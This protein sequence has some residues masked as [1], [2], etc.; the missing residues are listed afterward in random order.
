[1]TKRRMPKA[2][3]N[4]DNR[5]E[6]TLLGAVVA[7]LIIAACLTAASSLIKSTSKAQR[8]IQSRA[9]LTELGVTLGM[10]LNNPDLCRKALWS[11]G[12]T[13][14][15][16][17]IASFNPDAAS[18]V[19][20]GKR[21][22]TI[23]FGDTPLIS[24]GGKLN[25]ASTIRELSLS[26][27]D[28]TLRRSDASTIRYLANLRVSIDRDRKLAVGGGSSLSFPLHVVTNKS[29]HQITAC[30]RVAEA[31]GGLPG[32]ARGLVVRNLATTPDRAISIAYKDLVLTDEGLASITVR[33]GNLTAFINS[34]GAN[35]LDVGVKAIHSWYYL[36]VVSDGAN[37]V[38]LFSLSSTSPKLPSGYY[39]KA[40]VSAVS[41]DGAGNFRTFR[42]AGKAVQYAKAYGV[43][44]GTPW[45]YVGWN[46]PVTCMNPTTPTAV[47]LAAYVP[48]IAVSGKF[49]LF[50]Y[51]TAVLPWSWASCNLSMDSTPGN[52]TV[53]AEGRRGGDGFVM[54]RSSGE[55]VF[56][57]PSTVYYHSKI[58]SV[59]GVTWIAGFVLGEAM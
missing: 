23:R 25:A 57:T 31:T 38:S 45:D 39:Y 22:F 24:V 47:S 49:Q 7:S 43:G 36:W 27:V 21:L 46:G 54:G 6:I 48:P 56:D 30:N 59:C 55:I 40:L 42:Q 28:K 14:S 26:E 18:S 12:T 1:M 37:E 52:F 19:P 29:T 35:G 20:A 44:T 4:L 8:T 53:Q 9:D 32:D 50:C 58:G 34:K 51:A 11:A 16:P 13:A 3:I 41:T 5:G 10:I 15:V 17:Q 2:A 33:N